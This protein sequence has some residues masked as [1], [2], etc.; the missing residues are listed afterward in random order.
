MLGD[1]EGDSIQTSLKLLF[2]LQ[3]KWNVVSASGLLGRD[4]N[5]WP[6]LR[7]AVAHSWSTP[8]NFPLPKYNRDKIYI[9]PYQVSRE[10]LDIFSWLCKV[11]GNSPSPSFWI[12]GAKVLIKLNCLGP[13]SSRPTFL[14][15]GPWAYHSGPFL[16]VGPWAYHSGSFLDIG[17]WAYHS[18]LSWI[19]G[20]G[21]TI[22]GHS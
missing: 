15:I 8:L 17:P 4:L 6:S 12:G 1:G 18:G 19:S 9:L 14:N 22:Q 10:G 11:H 2:A 21:H 5:S 20:G 13:S 7:Q 3:Q 16:V